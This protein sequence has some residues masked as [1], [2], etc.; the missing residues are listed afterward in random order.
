MNFG[1]A[2]EALKMGKK[3]SRDS[4]EATIDDPRGVQRV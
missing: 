3:V 2:I 4:V 1:N